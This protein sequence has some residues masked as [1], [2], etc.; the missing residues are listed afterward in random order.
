M[1]ESYAVALC[2]HGNS[3][4]WFIDWAFNG[5]IHN[6]RL[7]RAIS[8]RI[9]FNEFWVT[10]SR[11]GSAQKDFTF[12]IDT[13]DPDVTTLGG[14][15]KFLLL[16][17]QVER[18]YPVL[19]D[20]VVYCGAEIHGP[21]GIHFT[22]GGSISDR[23]EQDILFWRRQAGIRR[24]HIA[25]PAAAIANVYMAFYPEDCRKTNQKRIVVCEGEVAFAAIM[26][27]W[28]LIDSLEYH[29]LEGQ[30]LS[31]ALLDQWRDFALSNHTFRDTDFEPLIIGDGSTVSS[32]SNLEVWNPFD[33]EVIKIRS[34]YAQRTILRYPGAAAVAFGMAMQGG[35]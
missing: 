23:I 32:N 20:P 25:S 14:R 9:W 5:E 33:S 22:G 6:K 34:E 4:G 12:A 26:D 16:K 1:Q 24:P 29:M 28:K 17:T 13:V 2:A 8:D 21:D 30:R 19:V 31:K 10:P 11:S 27:G 15:T 35:E 18:R 7:L 3:G